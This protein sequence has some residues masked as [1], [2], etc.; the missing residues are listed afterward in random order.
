MLSGV[1]LVPEGSSVATDVVIAWHV[2]P[3]KNLKSIQDRGLQTKLGKRSRRAKEVDPAIFLFPDGAS[4]E[5]ALMGWMSDEFDDV[6]L[7][8]I[9]VSIPKSWIEESK[10]GWELVVRKLIPSSAIKVLLQNIQD[11]T[12]GYPGETQPESWIQVK[13]ESN[14]SPHLTALK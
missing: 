10:V 12:G 11:W 9:E 4:L 7:A 14:E 8:L 5:D 6:Q 1:N 13:Q 2:T 3:A